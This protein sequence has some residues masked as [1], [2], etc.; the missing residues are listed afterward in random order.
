[1]SWLFFAAYHG[2][3]LADGHAGKVNQAVV[4][5]ANSTGQGWRD[6]AGLGRI[7]QN[8]LN[9]ARAIVLDSIPRKP[10]LKPSVVPLKTVSRQGTKGHTISDLFALEVV[11]IGVLR[12]ATIWAANGPRSKSNPR[13]ESDG[14]PRKHSG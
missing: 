4:F 12:G 9:N 2:R 11:R 14:P 10:A 3:S 1:M 5:E 13:V 7:I 6:A 8:R